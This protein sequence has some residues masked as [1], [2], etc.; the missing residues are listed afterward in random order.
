MHDF[1]THEKEIDDIDF[2]PD[3]ARLLS[4]SKDKVSLDAVLEWRQIR[5]F[6]LSQLF[7]S[8]SHPFQR[9]IVWDV[10]KGKKH[11]ELGWESPAGVKYIFKVKTNQNHLE[12]SSCTQP[13]NYPEDHIDSLLA[14]Y[15][16]HFV[17]RVKFG[18]VEGDQR[19]YKV[20]TISNPVG[21]SKVGQESM[22]LIKQIISVCNQFLEIIP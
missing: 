19:K 5:L 4:I 16:P 17:Q 7:H 10:K 2:S 8:I 6:L 18:C 20:Y 11:A 15:H 13:T 1:A 21:S 22:N 14:C 12:K 9:A 3:S